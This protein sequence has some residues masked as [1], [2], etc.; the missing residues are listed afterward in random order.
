VNVADDWGRRLA[1]DLADL[2]RAP[3]IT[4]GLSD[5]AEI[6]PE[7]LESTAS[8]SRF[9]AGGIEIETPLRGAFNVENVL[10]AIAAGILLDL[11]EDDIAAGIASVA[12]VPGRFE[13]VD[14]GQSFT[15]L[16]DF[17]HTPDSLESVLRSARGL[18]EGR[19]IVV[20]GAGG[21]RDRGKRPLM[22]RV[23]ANLADVT[24]VTSDNPR[25]EEPIRIIEDV[26]QG[27]GLDVEVDPDRRTAVERAI[28]VAEPGD[29]VVIAGKGHE[30][31]QEVAGVVHPFDDREVAREAIR[32]LAQ[33]GEEG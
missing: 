4:F 31:G 15:V 25:S 18:T 17:A 6:R 26:L 1:A 9:H 21:D 16:V 12:G 5:D 14:E 32:R 19:V 13:P 27:A 24:I 7:G 8:G 2:H 10:G 3:L 29:V 33:S 20:F 23:A 11:D 30:Q 28:S 22:G